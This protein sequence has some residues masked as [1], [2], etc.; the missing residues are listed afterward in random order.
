ML[1]LLYFQNLM[2]KDTHYKNPIIHK[3]LADK[4]I[5]NYSMILIKNLTF[6]DKT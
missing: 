2:D 4:R 3:K 6:I 1:V 5:I